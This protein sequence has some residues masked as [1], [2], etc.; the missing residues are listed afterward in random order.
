MFLIILYSAPY[1]NLASLFDR[2]LGITDTVG[3]KM[4]FNGESHNMTV[5]SLALQLVTVNSS[6]FRGL[7][8]GVSSFTNNNSPEVRGGTLE[9]RSGGGGAAGIGGMAIKLWFN[10]HSGNDYKSHDSLPEK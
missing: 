10:P 4:D 9:S 6:L 1:F 8:F 2:I 3:D 5:P 7:T